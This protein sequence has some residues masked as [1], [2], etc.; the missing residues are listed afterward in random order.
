MT[1]YGSRLLLGVTVVAAWELLS[2]V[3][4]DPFFFS[5]PSAIVAALG[6]L[7]ESGQFTRHVGLTVEE[8]LL[9]YVFGAVAAIVAAALLGLFPRGYAIVEPF[10]LVIYSVPSVAI[11]PLLIVWFGIGLLPKIILAAYFVFF[12][13]LMNGIAGI[14]GVPSGWV[15]VTRVMGASRLQVTTKVVLRAGAPHLMVGLRTA[16]PQAVIGAVVAEF[17]S[18]QR[19]IGFLISDASAHYNTAGVFVA[20]LIL[21]VLVLLMAAVL[22]SRR[23]LRIGSRTA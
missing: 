10:I 5:R 23:L 12:V 18:S 7:F 21:S 14:R 4:L 2:G 22:N 13:V 6:T 19:G 1:I 8:A 15:N 11:A 20:I 9:G 16:L 3:I 17:I